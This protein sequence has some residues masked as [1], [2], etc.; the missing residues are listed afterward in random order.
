MK[1]FKEIVFEDPGF[2]VLKGY[3]NIETRCL[4][5]KPLHRY[6]NV[7][8]FWTTTKNDRNNVSH[9]F[10][11]YNWVNSHNIS[12]GPSE[13]RLMELS[14]IKDFWDELYCFGRPSHFYPNGKIKFQE[15]YID[16]QGKLLYK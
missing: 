4:C 15:S 5:E 16:L 7:Y 11:H 8:S 13:W 6:G 3:G 10:G 14:E 1:K 12:Y 2:Y 9:D